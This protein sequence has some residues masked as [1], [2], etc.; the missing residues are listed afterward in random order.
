[1]ASSGPSTR[2]GVAPAASAARASWSPNRCSPLQY[3][4]VPGVLRYLGPAR[5]LAAALGLRRAMEPT[6]APSRA[7][8]GAGDETDDRAGEVGD[9]EGEPVAEP[10]DQR[11]G[12]GA[13]GEAR[14]DQ[15]GI[16]GAEP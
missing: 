5:S 7:V 6:V 8:A 12:T 2:A 11:V 1:M 3:R 13:L 9:G 15:F 10:V 16:G 4:S 14:G